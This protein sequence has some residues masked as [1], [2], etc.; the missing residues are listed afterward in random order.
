MSIYFSVHTFPLY[1]NRRQFQG[2]D[3]KRIATFANKSTTDKKRFIFDFE[4]A[5]R[6][7][8]R[9]IEINEIL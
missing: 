5:D 8:G 6:R 9:G 4:G 7:V 3:K 2:L 1:D